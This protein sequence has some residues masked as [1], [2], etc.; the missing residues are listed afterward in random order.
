M[1]TPSYPHPNNP[2]V[3]QNPASTLVVGAEYQR[4][5]S[6]PHSD[7]GIVGDLIDLIT[8]YFDEYTTATSR[9]PGAAS[10]AEVREFHELKA[11]FK[12]MFSKNRGGLDHR[13]ARA[14]KVRKPLV[15]NFLG[16]VLSFHQGKS[17]VTL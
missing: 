6:P 10:I 9:H 11:K 17:S 4:S 8:I 5:S 2:V 1:S 16:I 14:E 13:L 15:M 3:P 12:T 7:Q